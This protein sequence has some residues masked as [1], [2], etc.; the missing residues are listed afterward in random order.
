MSTKK[1]NSR[2]VAGPMIVNALLTKTMGLTR[3]EMRSIGIPFKLNPYGNNAADFALIDLQKRGVVRVAGFK[4]GKRNGQGSSIYQL[5]N[6]SAYNEMLPVGGNHALPRP[7]L[8]AKRKG[9]KSRKIK[10]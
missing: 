9:K 8:A 7:S 3:H 4:S 6:T 5:T 1:F 2:A 10:A